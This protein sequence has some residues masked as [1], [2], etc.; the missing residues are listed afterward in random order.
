MSELLPKSLALAIAALV[1]PSLVARDAGRVT[2]DSP[3][4]KTP[5]QA[6][7]LLA[8]WR[9]GGQELWFGKNPEA[10]A[11]LGERF[12]SLHEAAARG[13]LDG[14]AD[15]PTGALALVIL[16]DQFPRN[17]FRGTAR[18]YATDARAVAVAGR[19]LDRGYMEMVPPDL[20]LFLR[21]PFAHSENLPDQERSVD[22]A[23]R[24]DPASLAYAERHRGIIY[25]FGRFPHRNSIL[26]RK[27]RAEERHYLANG[28]F[29][30]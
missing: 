10:D 1:P 15:T 9:E 16:L 17:S 19:A 14:W 13:D 8:Y 30:G 22:L 23:R 28:G 11:R 12:L 6:R 24:H 29:Q 25:R 3:S 21:L 4:I 20:R 18:M 2:S 5:A 7:E 27:S 26:G